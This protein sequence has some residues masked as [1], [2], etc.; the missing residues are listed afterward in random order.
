MVVLPRSFGCGSS[1]KRIPKHTFKFAEKNQ[2]FDGILSFLHHL[3]AGCQLCYKSVGTLYHPVKEC[4]CLTNP[5]PCIVLD[6]TSIKPV[7]RW[8]TFDIEA[9]LKIFILS[10]VYFGKVAR[11]IL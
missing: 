2:I 5:S 4:F 6:D 7:K 11:G 8:I 3:L 1:F 10:N 9:L